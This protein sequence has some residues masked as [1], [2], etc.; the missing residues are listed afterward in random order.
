MFLYSFSV[1]ELLTVV[2]IILIVALHIDEWDFDWVSK[3]QLIKTDSSF[4]GVFQLNP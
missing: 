1:I 2:D 3:S 4:K